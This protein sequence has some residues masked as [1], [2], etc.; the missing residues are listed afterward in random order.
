M[1]SIKLNH[2]I[3]NQKMKQMGYRPVDLSKKLKVSRQMVNYIL[4]KGGVLYAGRLAQILKCDK[5]DIIIGAVHK[6]DRFVVLNNKVSR[7]KTQ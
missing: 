7:I 3:V 5:D 2:K 4:Y 1:A 6:P